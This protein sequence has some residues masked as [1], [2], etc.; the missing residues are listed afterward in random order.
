M[1]AT[2]AGQNRP[3]AAPASCNDDVLVV[4]L[5]QDLRHD[6]LAAWD[7]PTARAG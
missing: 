1:V 6:R 7:T 5:Q 4:R 3:F 2:L